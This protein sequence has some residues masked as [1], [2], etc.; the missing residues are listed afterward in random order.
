MKKMTLEQAINK[1]YDKYTVLQ[2]ENAFIE[3]GEKYVSVTPSGF[4]LSH[5]QYYT[6]GYL[7]LLRHIAK[8]LSRYTDKKVYYG[9]GS[10]FS[11]S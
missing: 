11:M 6:D 7:R 5:R 9:Q 8:F 4:I 10:L 2:K 3:N 1:A